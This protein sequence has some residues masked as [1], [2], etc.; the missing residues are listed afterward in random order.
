MRKVLFDDDILSVHGQQHAGFYGGACDILRFAGADADTCGRALQKGR[1]RLVRGGS[2]KE[3][4]TCKNGGS[5]VFGVF[6][7]FI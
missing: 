3:R 7:P 5:A 6:L 1:L 2:Q 4:D